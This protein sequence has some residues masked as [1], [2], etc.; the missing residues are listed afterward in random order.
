MV[1]GYAVPRLRL[2]IMLRENSSGT[3]EE[4]PVTKLLDRVNDANDNYRG[5][6]VLHSVT[7]KRRKHTCV[8]VMFLVTGNPVKYLRFS[9]IDSPVDVG[10]PVCCG[11]EVGMEEDT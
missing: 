9:T 1:A 8:L 6:F 5:G 4:I 11:E 2:N 3:D 7:Y 10:N